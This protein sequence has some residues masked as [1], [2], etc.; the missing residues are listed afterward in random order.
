[1]D[2]HLLKF[3]HLQNRVLVVIG[4]L[5]RCAPVC[6]LHVAFRIPYAYDYIT[7]LCRTQV[8]ILNHLNL[9]YVVLGKEKP[10]TEIIRG[11]NFVAVRPMAV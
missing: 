9:M 10:G 2:V 4:S 5:D 1:V 11:F 3:H 8:V 7:K 6:D